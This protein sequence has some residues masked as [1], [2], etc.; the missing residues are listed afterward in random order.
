MC[1]SSDDLPPEEK[2]R[3]KAEQA[4][5]KKLDTAMAS[6]NAA[7][8]QINKL[9]LLGAGE[10]GKSTLFKQ[11]ITIYGKGYPESERKTF[12]PIIW[13]NI[14]TSMKS[15]VQ[16]AQTYGPIQTPQAKVAANIIENE[17]KG[18]EEI[19]R[20]LGQHIKDL[21]TDEGIK[22]TYDQR[23]KYQ[24]FDSAEYFFDRIDAICSDG[25]VPSEQDVLR[26][27][28]R[29][30]G[31]VENEFEIDGNQFKMFDVGGQRNE[32]KKWIHCFENVTAVI[33]VAA[34]SEYDQVL[35][36]DENTNRMVEALNLFEEICNSRWFRE[37]AMILFLNKRDL[38]A[39]K[40][41]KVSL[42]V[43]FPEYEGDDTYDAGCAFLQ[44]QFEVKN[45]NPE[46]QV[47]THVTCATDTGN[48]SAV[49][50][51]VKDIIIRR[52]LNEAGLV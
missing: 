20:N 51:A 7:D 41:E 3:R 30:T 27:R 50:D 4:R 28:V 5:S 1:G 19:D 33:F 46:K 47:Y 6:E 2:A 11:M 44:E 9:L 24:L 17:L 36:E 38:F 18:D 12:T 32:R 34:I 35:Y 49:F 23:S 13:N 42:R 15:L 22:A 26:S 16:Q 29:T 31:I 37:T 14:I 45:R 39:Q 8:Q 21:W 48:I 52:S 25:Y 10:S 43:C 40:I